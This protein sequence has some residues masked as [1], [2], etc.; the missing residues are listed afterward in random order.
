MKYVA[1]EEDANP[2]KVKTF[3]ATNRRREGF[4]KRYDITLRVQTNK[5]SRSAIKR[6]R[7]VKL[8]LVHDV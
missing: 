7:I 3:K 8:L 5:K 6:S 4:C 1:M 2:E